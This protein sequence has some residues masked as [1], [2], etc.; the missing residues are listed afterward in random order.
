[1]NKQL[2]VMPATK[3][4]IGFVFD[5]SLDSNDGVAQYVKTLG[6][7]LSS[8]GHHVS[9]LVG[10]TKSSQWQGGKIFSL[11][12]NVQVR[13]NGNRVGIPLPAKQAAIKR[14]LAAESF[15]V[16][17]VQV[18]Y[19]PFMAGKIIGRARPG[20]AI[21]GTFH[22]F[23]YGLIAQVGGRLLGLLSYRTLKRFDKIVSVSDVAASFAQ[24][25]FGI[26]TNV[27]PNVVDVAFYKQHARP[28]NTG[29]NIVFLG[30]LVERKGCG[31]L[32]DAFAHLSK[33]MPGVQLHIAGTGAGRA[34]LERKVAR[35]KLTDRVTFHGFVSEEAKAQLLSTADVA[36]FPSTGG[37]S[38]G[39]VLVEAMAAGA[40]AV[41]GGNNP[42]YKT[43][44]GAQPDLLI[45]PKKTADFGERLERLL[46]DTDL[47]SRVY[48]WQQE[49]LAKYDVAQVG[50]KLETLYSQAI[51]NKRT[52]KA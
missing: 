37:E 47:T 21:I 50:Q 34:D 6:G 20:T 44:L 28:A 43:V 23:P 2:S 1:M 36:C 51:A 8:R 52:T 41:L 13:F 32:L 24:K 48:G 16:L 29:K 10:E 46:S 30:R 11:A 12:K 18:P 5:D 7:W 39:I 33:K 27:V 22:I 25:S 4:K 38:F 35:L 26:K 19:S 42:G 31:Y 49:Q 17:H 40:K 14:V 15:D 3:L 45:D 9:Y